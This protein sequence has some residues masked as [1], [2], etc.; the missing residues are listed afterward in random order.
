MK[1]SPHSPVRH[2]SFPLTL[3]HSLHAIMRLRI[4]LCSLS[5]MTLPA[6]PQLAAE[7]GGSFSLAAQN[8]RAV[9]RSQENLARAQSLMRQ[10]MEKRAQHHLDAAYQDAVESLRMAPSGSAAGPA[11]TALIADYSGIALEESRELIS[12]GRYIEAQTVAKSILDPAVN[13]GN[14]EAVR[15]LSDLEQPEIFNK[16]VTPKSA[17]QR[18]QVVKLLREAEGLTQSGRYDLALKQYDA[19]LRIDPYNN[20][21]R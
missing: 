19:V 21:A 7:S 4:G 20:A 9:I 3:L 15:L 2:H 12:G 6:I 18:D 16:T 13:P 11:R 1:T 14:K 17:A 5:L 8:E 10:A